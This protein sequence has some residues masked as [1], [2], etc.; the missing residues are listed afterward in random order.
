MLYLSLRGR[1]EEGNQKQGKSG[2]RVGR[3]ICERFG[4]QLF[5]MYT[6]VWRTKDRYIS[7]KKASYLQN[8]VFYGTANFQHS[9][10]TFLSLILYSTTR[11]TR[12]RISREK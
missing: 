12:I 10:I 7:Y 5:S 9:E 3:A 1:R 11:K 6:R 8:T 2:S 4:M